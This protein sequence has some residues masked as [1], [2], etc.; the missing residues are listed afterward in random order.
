MQGK[1]YCK[2]GPRRLPRFCLRVCSH[3]LLLKLY[4]RYVISRGANLRGALGGIICNFCP[5]F[6]IGEMNLDHDIFQVSKLSREEQKNW[7]KRSSPKIEEFCPR[8]QVKTKKP[9]QTSS[10]AQTQPRVKVLGGMQMYTIVNL[11]GGIY[12]HRVSAPLVISNLF[13]FL[14]TR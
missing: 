1:N 5:I 4:F 10:S 12:P 7:K 9:I 8:I 13:F 2:T 6:N 3:L 14:R 11:L